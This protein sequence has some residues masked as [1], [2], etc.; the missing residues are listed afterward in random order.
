MRII[1]LNLILL[2]SS[3][4]NAQIINHGSFENTLNNN[5]VS[6]SGQFTDFVNGWANGNEEGT[7][8]LYSINSSDQDF[9]IP[10]NI[11]TGGSGSNNQLETAE[12]DNYVGIQT[13]YDFN[14][15]TTEY[16][17][18]PPERSFRTTLFIFET[19]K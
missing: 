2:L 4:S 17:K 15:N 8:D 1:I 7:P 13:F 19:L 16:I 11:S 3:L 5:I 9:D 10:K 14:G 12:G 18:T 6:G